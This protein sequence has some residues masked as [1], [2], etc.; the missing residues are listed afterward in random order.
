MNILLPSIAG[1]TLVLTLAGCVPAH[2]EKC[3]VETTVP[4]LTSTCEVYQGGGEWLGPASGIGG[5]TPDNGASSDDNG[6][7]TVDDHGPDDNG[8][9]SDG[10]SDDGNGGK[11]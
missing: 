2:R 4:P 8:G 10:S 7:P 11:S 1:V 5:D 3:V 6:G 9:S